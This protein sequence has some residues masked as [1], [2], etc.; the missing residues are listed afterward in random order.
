[1][2]LPLWEPRKKCRVCVLSGDGPRP[3]RDRQTDSRGLRWLVDSFLWRGVRTLGTHTIKQ[4][5]G[6]ILFSI[7]LSF[8]TFYQFIYDLFFVFHQVQIQAWIASV[9]K[10]ILSSY[11][12]IF[13][14]Y[15]LIF[16]LVSSW[17]FHFLNFYFLLCFLDTFKQYNH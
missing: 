14:F 4:V 1:M 8:F 17:F 10:H 11:A 2:N 12:I 5:Y 16:N 6:Q 9:A 15:L 13:S 7:F 3:I